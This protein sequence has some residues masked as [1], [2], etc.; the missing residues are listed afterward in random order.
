MTTPPAVLRVEGLTV[1]LPEDA[2]R[3]HAIRDFSITVQAGEIV[4]LVGESGSGK[5]VSAFST[6]G[7]L[8]KALT[9]TAGS[10]QLA[11]E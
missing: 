4:C 8:P 2:D 6:M 7:L 11:G 5:S 10:I 9:V 1:A 3:A